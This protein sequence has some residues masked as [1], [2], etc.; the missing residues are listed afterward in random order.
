MASWK[1]IAGVGVAL[2]LVAGIAAATAPPASTV[3]KSIDLKPAFA[4]RSP[5]RLTA[6]QGPGIDD[7]LGM[8]DEKAPGNI[9]LCL[10]ETAAGP[11]DASLQSALAPTSDDDLFG[12]PHFLNDMEVVHPRGSSGRALLVVQTASLHSVDGDQAVLTQVLAYDAASD[13]FVRVYEHG[14]GHNNNQEVRYIAAGK[15]QGDVILVEPAAK[16]P[17]NYWVTVNALTPAYTYRQVLKYR[18]ATRYGDGNPLSVTDSE[19][20]NIEQRVGLWRPGSPLPLPA[21][22]CPKPRLTKMELWCS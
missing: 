4:T 22:P 8:S 16:A 6:T 3:I 1:R 9:Q 20:P 7:P 18:S 10:S 13:R 2:A 11:C 12:Q 17:F 15:L 5:W 14:T 21:G 19:L